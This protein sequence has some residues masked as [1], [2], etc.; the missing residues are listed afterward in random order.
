MTSSDE[1]KMFAGYNDGIILLWDVGTL[2]VIMRM[3]G[4]TPGASFSC[5]RRRII[6]SR[7]RAPPMTVYLEQQRKLQRQRSG[8]DELKRLK[9]GTK[10]VESRQGKVMAP[11]DITHF[12]YSYV[13]VSGN[14]NWH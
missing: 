9:E 1:S 13:S 11:Q 2:S 12:N 10:E 4:D 7:N 5:M 3:E 8:E 6:A 14:C